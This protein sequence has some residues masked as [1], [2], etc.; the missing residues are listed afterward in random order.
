MNFWSHVHPNMQQT[1]AVLGVDSGCCSVTYHVDMWRRC[2]PPVCD[3]RACGQELDVSASLVC[4]LCCARA[5]DMEETTQRNGRVKNVNVCV[6]ARARS[7]KEHV[8]R[9]THSCTETFSSAWLPARPRAR[10]AD[11]RLARALKPKHVVRTGRRC[12]SRHSKLFDQPTDS[13]Q[14]RTRGGD[15]AY[16]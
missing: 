3:L 9:G 15:D 11:H 12:P 2:T 1:C 4:G 16:P 5:Q 7:N 8:V 10:A 14:R 6:A 13:S